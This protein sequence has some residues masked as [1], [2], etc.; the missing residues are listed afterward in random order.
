MSD[1]C[2]LA[3]VIAD[4][5]FLKAPPDR[6]QGGMLPFAGQ[7][8]LCFLKGGIVQRPP[9]HTPTAVQLR[10]RAV[11]R[12]Q[13]LA[14]R[15]AAKRTVTAV[16]IDVKFVVHLPADH[17]GVRAEAARKA[18]GD[19]AVLFPHQRGGFA[20][21]TAG[22]NC[23]AHACGGHLPR[24]GVLVQK[25]ARRGAGGGAENDRQPCRMEEVDDAREPIEVK[26]PFGRFCPT[27]REFADAQHAQ[28]V[29]ATPFDIL[30]NFIFIPQL[31]IVSGSKLNHL[32]GFSFGYA[33]S[34]NY[35]FKASPR[36]SRLAHSLAPFP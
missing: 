28:T 35:L 19:V 22:G 5:R 24:F 34:I 2:L 21:V 8:R 30:F 33:I 14:E 16:P 10:N 15:R 25:P 26:L 11:L 23:L 32:S 13:I 1:V 31:G 4:L 27:P 20:G 18:L 36:N 12:L 9:R 3:G 17:G 7:G 6:A 29:G